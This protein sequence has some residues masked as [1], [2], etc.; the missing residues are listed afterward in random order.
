MI[1]KVILGHVRNFYSK[2]LSNLKYFFFE[3][4]LAIFIFL[5]CINKD[6]ESGN[7]ESYNKVIMNNA[8]EESQKFSFCT[9]V[10]LSFLLFIKTIITPYL[11]S[12]T[13]LV[14]W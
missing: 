4:S 1:S 11:V 3:N 9:T 5:G 6:I 8:S 2:I 14:V 12:K 10:E 7:R 13:N